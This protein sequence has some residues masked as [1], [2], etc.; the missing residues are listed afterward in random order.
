MSSFLIFIDRPEETVSLRIPDG[1][2]S[3]ATVIE[4]S[5]LSCPYPTML[6]S[7]NQIG[8]D[9]LHY[10]ASV[11][12]GD[13]EAALLWVIQGKLDEET[14]ETVVAPEFKDIFTMRLEQSG[15]ALTMST[16]DDVSLKFVGSW[17][18]PFSLFRL[19]GNSTPLPGGGF[20]DFAFNCLARG[21]DI[22]FYGRFLKLAGM[23]DRSTGIINVSGGARVSIME[24]AG[25]PPAASLGDVDLEMTDSRILAPIPR[26]DSRECGS[27]S[28]HLAGG[29]P[30][31][32]GDS[33]RL[34]ERNRNAFRRF[35]FP[36]ENRSG[37]AG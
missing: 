37:I 23:A 32:K 24:E 35:G 31:G 34:R 11:V 2:G 33:R 10:L 12:E 21:E 14:G 8:F 6:P 4:I 18:M 36:E 26:F 22:E 30:D 7:Y 17:D 9:S 20:S 13:D 19:A 28:R 3:P 1:K 29:F 15:S 5:R 16:Y 25:L 27:C